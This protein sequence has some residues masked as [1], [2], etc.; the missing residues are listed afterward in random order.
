MFAEFLISLV[1]AF[2]YLGLFAASVIGSA[3][4]I[5]PVPIFLL[6]FV[7]GSMLNPLAVGIIAGIGSAIGEMTAYAIGF[8]GR[9]LL[10]KNGKKLKKKKPAKAEGSSKWFRRAEEW[11]HKRGGFLV[12]FLFAVTPLP[13]DVIGIIC[14]SIRYDIKKFFIACLLGKIILSLGIAYAGFYGAQW[15]LSYL[16]LLCV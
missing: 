8:G 12:I 9:K 6:I 3:S 11:M 4:V 5:L 16:G 7:A 15:I 1:Y 2:G 13:D 10:W 14:G